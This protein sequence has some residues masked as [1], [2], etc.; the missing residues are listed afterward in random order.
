MRPFD[1][2]VASILVLSVLTGGARAQTKHDN[3]YWLS[4]INKAS[5]VMTVE[6]KIVPAALGA[7]IADAVAR[8]IA[9][10]DKPGAQRSQDYLV[11]ERGLIAYG[12]PDVTRLH[13]GRSRQDIGATMQRLGAREDFLAAFAKLS[14]ARDAA[15][16]LAGRAPNAIV[17]AY[18][19]GVQAQPISFGH[20]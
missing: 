4:E 15:L 16:A 12:G 7:R 20:Y 6:Q 14:E 13:S 2:V 9:D 3:F 11:I 8:V 10:G 18:T 19:W 17:P 1:R 5:A